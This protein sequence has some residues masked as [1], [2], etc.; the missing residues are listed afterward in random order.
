VVIAR[1]PSPELA[2]A[3]KARD[4]LSV[5]SLLSTRQE[6]ALLGFPCTTHYSM[7][8]ELGEWRGRLFFPSDFGESVIWALG[9]RSKGVFGST[10]RKDKRKVSRL[11]RRTTAAPA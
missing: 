6:R 2:A 7:P 9:Q 4:E 8:P 5:A 11:T 1:P 3:I 10:E